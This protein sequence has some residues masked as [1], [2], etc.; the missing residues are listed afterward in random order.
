MKNVSLFGKVLI[1]KTPNALAFHLHDA[2]VV[3]SL[4]S[5][6]IGF[7]TTLVVYGSQKKRGATVDYTYE[8]TRVWQNENLRPVLISYPRRKMQ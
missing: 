3:S 6:D 4:E 5:V 2:L 8:N 7:Y 1:L